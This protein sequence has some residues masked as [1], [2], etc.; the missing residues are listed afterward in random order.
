MS[1]NALIMAVVILGLALLFSV[2]V[3]VVLFILLRE[4]Y[5]EISS[6]YVPVSL[7]EIAW[8]WKE[9]GTD[10]STRVAESEV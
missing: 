8:R 5:R 9:V 4:A 1:T 10:G 6:F 2:A 7:P 3:I